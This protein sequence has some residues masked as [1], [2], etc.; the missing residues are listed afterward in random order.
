MLLDEPKKCCYY[1]KT[2]QQNR[3]R[4][5][6]KLRAVNTALSFISGVPGM[7]AI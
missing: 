2:S 4:V 1:M 6:M 3:P 7:G 5:R